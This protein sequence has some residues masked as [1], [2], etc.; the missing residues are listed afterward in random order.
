MAFTLLVDDT[1]PKCHRPTMRAVV[2]L[3]PSNSNLALQNF[4]CTECG[5][6]RTR[7]ISLKPGAGAPELSA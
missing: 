3:H 5:P 2:E 1:C 7:I 6:V 4:E